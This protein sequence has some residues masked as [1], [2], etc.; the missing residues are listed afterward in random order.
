MD[1]KDITYHFGSLKY[2]LNLINSFDVQVASHWGLSNTRG[3]CVHESMVN[4]SV[5]SSYISNYNIYE[6]N[7]KIAVY[8]KIS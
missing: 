6:N 1:K 8:Q 5:C 2:D 7:S 3:K 4:N